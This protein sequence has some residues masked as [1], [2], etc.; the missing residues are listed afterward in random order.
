[1]KD[2][3]ILLVY[4]HKRRF[5]E[6]DIRMLDN[7]Y[8]LTPLYFNDE[9]NKIK[10][11]VKQ[12]DLV[13]SWFASKH[14]IRP[15]FY[16]NRYNKK[17]MVIVGGFD[18]SDIDGYGMFSGFLKRRIVNYI[19]KNAD[20]IVPVDASLKEVIIDYIPSVK[21]KINVIPTGYDYNYFKPEGEK[22]NQVLTVCYVDQTNWW[23]KGINK[24]VEI[25]KI[26]KNNNEKWVFVIAGKISKD[27]KEK[28]QQLSYHSDSNIIFKDWITDE[29]L[30][31]LYQHSKIF[32]L[33]SKY[34]GLPNVLCEAMLCNCIPVGTD[35][36]G[37][38]NAIGDAGY[39]VS[40]DASSLSIY[41]IIKKAMNTKTTNKPR[42]RV[43]ELF[44]LEN[45]EKQL[46]KVIEEII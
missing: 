28:I 25:S 38:P 30:L 13:I 21:D 3:E 34:E 23:R 12:S 32:S 11:A 39:I 2:L 36:C 24:L 46:I 22:K 31:K 4:N 15:W 6:K 27:I 9:K 37:I 41:N 19:Y 40:K 44:N 7:L 26:A 43:K 5:V 1:M 10:N 33:L 29:E 8:N 16:A 45:R 14:T 35:V 17:K 42:K 18:A 20:L